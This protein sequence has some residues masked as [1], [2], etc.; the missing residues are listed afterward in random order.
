MLSG[1][2]PSGTVQNKLYILL[3]RHSLISF[4]I[5][6]H[7]PPLGRRIRY[8]YRKEMHLLLFFYA[9]FSPIIGIELLQFGRSS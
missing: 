5:N 6:A 4:V 3:T 7:I 8:F 9:L 1:K 2:I